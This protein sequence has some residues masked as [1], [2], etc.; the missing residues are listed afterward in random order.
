MLRSITWLYTST[1]SYLYQLVK[2]HKCIQ[3][4]KDVN[5]KYYRMWSTKELLFFICFPT[6]TGLIFPCLFFYCT[7]GWPRGRLILSAI[8][9]CWWLVLATRGHW[10]QSPKSWRG[11]GIPPVWGAIV[12]APS[13]QTSRKQWTW[14]NTL[15]QMS[16]RNTYSNISH[17]VE[18]FYQQKGKI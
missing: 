15:L 16:T 9:R 17:N 2:N 3:T 11:R 14:V 4:W 12:A 10:R 7:G 5:V 8:S 6:R 1:C 18:L 13:R